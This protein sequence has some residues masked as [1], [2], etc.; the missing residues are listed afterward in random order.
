MPRRHRIDVDN[1][2]SGIA[3]STERNVPA[4][5]VASVESN[6]RDTIRKNP[7]E[8]SGGKSPR[9]NDHKASAVER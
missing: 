6:A 5:A 8:R 1:A 9:S 4:I 7:N 2:A 3:I